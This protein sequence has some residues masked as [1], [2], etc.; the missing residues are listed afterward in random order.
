MTALRF[1]RRPEWAPLA[2][3]ICIA[4]RRVKVCAAIH[5]D[6]DAP[7][8]V[9]GWDDNGGHISTNYPSRILPFVAHNQKASCAVMT[10]RCRAPQRRCDASLWTLRIRLAAL[11]PTPLTYHE[12]PCLLVENTKI[13]IIKM[14]SRLE[15][16]DRRPILHLKYF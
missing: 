15:L 11:D 13:A 14:P 6:L 10:R 12:A 16:G 4:H 2:S 5:L 7:S 8:T 1:A 3:P 9:R